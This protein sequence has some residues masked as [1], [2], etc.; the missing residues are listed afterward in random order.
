MLNIL[1]NYIDALK[2]GL[3]VTICAA[4]GFS[5][6]HFKLNNDTLK[7][8]IQTLEVKADAYKQGITAL[9]AAIKRQNDAIQAAKDAQILAEAKSAQ[10][11]EKARKATKEAEK[12]AGTIINT[13]KPEGVN[14][15]VAA[16]SLFEGV[17][18]GT[19]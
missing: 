17:I 15:C 11:I 10:E 14:E 9:Q 13:P 6:L 12:K 8:E 19:K 1:G 16:S 5:A 2:I 18:H 3:V 4:F 7:Q